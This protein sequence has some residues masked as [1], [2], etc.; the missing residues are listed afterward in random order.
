MTA[1]RGRDVRGASPRNLWSA[2]SLSAI[3]SMLGKPLSEEE[4]RYN[5]VT[6]RDTPRKDTEVGIIAGV[7]TAVP[8][9][10]V[11]ISPC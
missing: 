3:N 11:Q 1:A 6:S 9:S 7:S 10:L 4:V 5:Q 2:L 8:E